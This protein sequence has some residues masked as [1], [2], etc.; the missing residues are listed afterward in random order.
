MVHRAISRRLPTGRRRCLGLA[1]RSLAKAAS[2]HGRLADAGLSPVVLDANE[3]LALLNGTQFSTAYALAGLFE[4]ERLVQAALVPSALSVDAARGSDT[5]FDARI[6]ALRR[7]PGQAEVAAVLRALMDSSAIRASHR[8]GDE[9]VLDPYCL[10][11]QPQVMGAAADLLRQAAQTLQS[12][13]NGVSDN[14]LII[15]EDSIVL[16]GGNFHA[17]PVAFL[18]IWLRWQSPRSEEHVRAMLDYQRMGIPTVDYG[19][20]IRQMAREE[21]VPDAFDFPGFV[22]AYIR[23]L[24]CHGVGLLPEDAH[25]HPW[26]DM[27]RARIAFQGLPARICWVG[28]GDRHRLGLAFNEMVARGEVSA[29]IVIGRDHLD[30]GSVASPQSRNRWHAG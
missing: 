25:L 30:S 11:C 12:E 2:R 23:P 10:R 7:Q 19:N 18:L 1:M 28:L 5:R 3:G 16:S 9:R 27:A 26:L 22:P 6:H 4:A 29:P 14:P 17:E 13:A 24:F 15:S 21:G 20:K 8:T